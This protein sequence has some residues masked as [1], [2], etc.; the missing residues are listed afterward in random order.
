V[1]LRRRDGF[2]LIEMMAVVLLTTI[3]LSAAVSFYIDLASESGGHVVLLVA[4][5]ADTVRFE[6]VDDR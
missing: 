1:S 2:T 6:H 5:L 4:P 3:V